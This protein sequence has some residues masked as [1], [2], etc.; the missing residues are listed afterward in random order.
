MIYLEKEN[1][2]FLKTR[3]TAGTSLE[4]AL[5][6][7]A[8]ANDIV[9][10]V[11]VVDEILRRKA[12]GVFPQNWA[13]TP[14]A[15]AAFRETVEDFAASGKEV[16]PPGLM[17]WFK[18]QAVFFNHFGPDVVRPR[19]GADRFDRAL[20]VTVCRHPYEQLVSQAFFQMRHGEADF[21]QTV[22]RILD[23]PSPNSA[24]YLLEGKPVIDF[25]IRYESL[26]EDIAALE[27]RVGLELLTAMPH[28]KAGFRSDR[29]PAADQL[30]TEQ[31]ARCRKINRWE[32]DNLYD[33]A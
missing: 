31:K 6:M 13:R 27:R 7:Y 3:K 10:P 16:A 2:L 29:R 11:S 23:K 19:L 26:S 14:E 8:G 9:T 30:N 1:L 5:S 21:S 28:A 24:I 25:F 4:I 17:R 32:F 15:E 22:D 20:K 12:G 33:A 18:K